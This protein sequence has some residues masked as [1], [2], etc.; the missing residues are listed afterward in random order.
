MAVPRDL[1]WPFFEL[2]QAT[3]ARELDT[4]VAQHVA[5]A[6][7]HEVDAWCRALVR[8]LGGAGWW[9][10]RAGGQQFG[11]AAEAI[12][13]RAIYLIRETPA[14]HSG[15]ADFAFAMQ[16]PGSGAISLAG[17]LEQK[18]RYL[19]R[20]AAGD[21]VAAFALSEPQ[22]G[23]DMAALACT[24]RAQG[25]DYLLDGEKTWISNGGIGDFYVV[26][27]TGDGATCGATR[28][29]KGISAFI[30]DGG[31][32]GF[33]SPERIDMIVPHPLARLRFE[34]C[35][36]SHTQRVCAEGVG[37]KVAMHTLDVLRTSV[38]VAALGF[39]RRTLDKA[40]RAP[41]SARWSTAHSPIS[42]SRRPG[43][44]KWR[45]PST[46]SLCSPA[47]PRGSATRATTSRARRRW[48]RWWPPKARGSLSTPRCRSSAAW[49]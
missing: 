9:R 34:G 10:H 39:A 37:F 41:P 40:L 14:R 33:S 27:R 36:V 16:D 32:P 24:A 46:L 20:V 12:N 44:R 48:P 8:L 7:G 11:G 45:P 4:W 38:A 23:S 26:A 19:P 5:Q 17:T 2:R 42:S 15:L 6:H 29:T 49:A 1:D 22:A 31:T 43:W 13:T 35:R 47:A 30:V 3:L 25:D 18:Q 28:E 21:A